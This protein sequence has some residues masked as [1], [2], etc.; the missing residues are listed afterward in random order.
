MARI[1]Y[2]DLASQS[3][4]VLDRLRRTGSLNVNRMMSHAEGPMLAYSRLGVQLLLKGKLD[5]VLREIVILRVG[6]LCGSAYEWHQHVAVARA[7]AMDEATL[8]AVSEQAFDRLSDVQ[9][10]AVTIAEEIKRES[11]ARAE[12]ITRAQ[13]HLTSEQLVEL[14]LVAGYYIMTAGL[15]LSLDVEIEDGPSLGETMAT[16]R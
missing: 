5:P 14:I 1:A 7:V 4:E 10:I 12:T 13:L 6:Q 2:P 11:G 16:S 9:Q 15:L 8:Q 3:D